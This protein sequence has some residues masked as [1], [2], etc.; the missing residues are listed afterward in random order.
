VLW[1][2]A[3]AEEAICKGKQEQAGGMYGLVRNFCSA[4]VDILI[5]LDEISM[6][7]VLLG[8]LYKAHKKKK[9]L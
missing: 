8:G 2:G 6:A 1:G 3:I 4:R 7:D 9:S 5:K